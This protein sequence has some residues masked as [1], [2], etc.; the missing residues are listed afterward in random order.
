M[1]THIP[2]A[3]TRLYTETI[4]REITQACL[5]A[6]SVELVKRDL[7]SAKALDRAI[8]AV[9]E[10]YSASGDARTLLRSEP[11]IEA[12][13]GYS[14]AWDLAREYAKRLLEGVRGRL[15]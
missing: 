11:N 13:A 6:V 1:H 10:N 5:V 12:D 7:G 3:E 2:S 15:R 14:R 4:L 8:A 9:F